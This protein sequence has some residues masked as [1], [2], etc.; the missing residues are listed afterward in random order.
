MKH[1]AIIVVCT[2]AVSSFAFGNDVVIER[3][4]HGG[5]Q[6]QVA[7]GADG[8]V[9]LL[10]Y[11]GDARAGNVFYV[12]RSSDGGSWSEPLPVN[13][14][15]GSAVAAG[16]I[17]GAQLALGKAGRPHVVWN[18]SSEAQPRGSDGQAPL[19]YTRLR[20]DGDGFEPERNIVNTGYGLDGGGC[21]A[22]DRAGNV[23]VG[24]HGR[25]AQVG[26]EHRRVYVARSTDDGDTFAPE[27]AI[28]DGAGACGCCGMRGIATN[29]GQVLF[30][31]RTADKGLN[32]DICL[33]S[34]KDRGNNYRSETLDRWRINTCPMSSEAFV[35]T[36][37]GTWGAWETRERVFLANLA[38][39]SGATAPPRPVSNN[40]TKQKHPA[41][42]VNAGGDLLLVWT[43]G[44]GWERGGSFAWQG[45]DSLGRETD[46]HGRSP[47]IPV[48][49]F[50]AAYARPDGVFVILH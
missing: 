9:H 3:V 4:P 43:E 18:G 47:G 29:E 44:T 41:W 10:Y 6:P 45:F 49:S 13:Q 48:W 19:L 20:D 38:A 31:Y 2:L 27:R 50:A 23:Y 40:A 21:L 46:T 42:A 12:R 7:V 34:S 25:G 14:H 28:D 24:W 32:R 39:A 16:S 17:R 11:S 5:I 37:S 8:I 36:P 33:L 30:L 15:P 26:E 1:A 22:A 35:N